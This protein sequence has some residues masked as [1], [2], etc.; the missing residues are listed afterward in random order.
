[1]QQVKQIVWI[2]EVCREYSDEELLQL[3]N[4]SRANNVRR[5][6]TGLLIYDKKSFLQFM[7]G[8]AG[9]VDDIFQNRIE[10]SSL[11]RNVT[12]LSQRDIEERNFKNWTMGFYSIN[13]RELQSVSGFQE[14]KRNHSG[15]HELEGND[16]MVNK[17]IDGFQEGRW[18]LGQ[19]ENNPNPVIR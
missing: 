9:T 12:L 15:I 16:N 4:K 6:V 13:S 1:M 19:P 11:H 7:E 3:L 8:D 10:P 14:F 5:N 18:H 17:I 2:S